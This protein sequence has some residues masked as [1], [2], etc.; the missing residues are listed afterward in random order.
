M[1]TAYNQVMQYRDPEKLSIADNLG[2]AQTYKQTAYNTKFAEMQKLINTYAGLDLLRDIDKNYLGERLNTLVDYVNNANGPIDW[3]QNTIYNEIESFVGQALDTNVMRAISSTQMYRNHQAEMAEYKKNKPD[4][5]SLQ[6]DWLATRDLNRYLNSNQIGDMYQHQSYTPYFDYKK[7][8]LANTKLLKDFGAEAYI[9]ASSG[10]M[11]FRRIDTRERIS[12]EKAAEFVDAIIGDKGKQQMAI[13]GMYHYRNY[14][15][16]DLSKQYKTYLNNT[17][18]GYEDSIK[19]YKALLASVPKEQREQYESQIKYLQDAATQYKNAAT[20]NYDRDTMASD[21]HSRSIRGTWGKLLS[22]DKL[23]DWKMDDSGFKIA[24]F[25]FDKKK[26]ADNMAIKQAEMEMDREKFMLEMYTKGVK[27]DANGNFVLDSSSPFAPGITTIDNAEE[28]KTEENDP[29]IDVYS[30]FNNSWAQLDDEGNV[31]TF[32]DAAKKAGISEIEGFTTGD[33]KTLMRKMADAD[34]SVYSKFWNAIPDNLRNVIAG[35]KEA[36]KARDQHQEDMRE[37]WEDVSQLASGMG[38]GKFK[39]NNFQLYLNDYGLDKDGNVIKKDEKDIKSGT[40]KEDRVLR[41]IGILNNMTYTGKNGPGE[42]AAIRARQI[43]L[44]KT[45][46][47][48]GRKLEE[49]KKQLILKYDNSVSGFFLNNDLARGV[50]N[51][52]SDINEFFGGASFRVG[53]EKSSA[54][55]IVRNRRDIFTPNFDLDDLADDDVGKS[56][57]RS[58]DDFYTRAEANYKKADE[59]AASYV[60]TT[61]RRSLSIDTSLKENQ[62]LESYFKS[63][64]PDGMTFNK[65]NNVKLT[66]SPDKQ[67]VELALPVK[68]GKELST[69]T[70]TINVNTLPPQLSSLIMNGNGGIYDANSSSALKFHSNYSLPRNNAEV[71]ERAK[72]SGDS[73]EVLATM[74]ALDRGGIPTYDTMIKTLKMSFGETVV[75]KHRAEIDRILTTSV[76]I[77]NDNVGG[78]WVT[79]ISQKGSPDLVIPNRTNKYDYNEM[80]RGTPELASEYIIEQIKNVVIG[81]Y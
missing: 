78:Q 16:E 66:M 25:E 77:S 67:S 12:P 52:A 11:Y 70:T 73:E 64:V 36:K 69:H 58:M 54:D 13:D 27:K 20:Q 48:H 34:E 33:I 46:G 19:A 68:N 63:Y 8:I 39:D 59:R 22:Y 38:K 21:L 2:K 23:T 9:D 80:K 51:I 5:Y 7:E 71:I 14:S 30:N 43:H 56:T 40:S 76:N 53:N 47:L 3:G 1:A 24:N 79:K 28:L 44:L 57:L 6:N 37:T 31:Q 61:L 29:T 26:H 81:G 62:A 45:L 32:R 15:T 49:A 74:D 41:E 4:M 65:E 35:A 60:K 72:K 75:N 55:A 10:D 18:K 42:R 17:A 50:R